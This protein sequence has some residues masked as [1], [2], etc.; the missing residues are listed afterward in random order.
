M[1]EVFV[2]AALARPCLSCNLGKTGFKIFQTLHNA[3]CAQ[4]QWTQCTQWSMHNDLGGKLQPWGKPVPRTVER[5]EVWGREDP[6][7]TAHSSYNL[8]SE[9]RLSLNILR[10]DNL[11]LKFRNEH[12]SER[13]D[14]GGEGWWGQWW[15]WQK[16]KFVTEKDKK[17]KLFPGREHK[18]AVSTFLWEEESPDAWSNLILSFIIGKCW[19][20]W[21]NWS[22]WS[23]WN[24]GVNFQSQVRR[25]RKAP[26]N[27]CCTLQGYP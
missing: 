13:D 1:Q 4:L 22:A 18:V 26:S 2:R 6:P 23:N 14:G 21:S 17:W 11:I 24:M 15:V 16:Y 8:C 7:I 5:T 9:C 12:I 3:Q 10:L 27:L 20:S 25:I 19:A